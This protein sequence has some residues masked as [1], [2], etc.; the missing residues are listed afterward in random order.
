MAIVGT[1]LAGML[2]AKARHTRQLAEAERQLAAVRAADELI[3][4][5][6]VSSTG[7]PIGRQGVVPGDV[8]WRW[9]TNIVENDSIRE[10]RAR[11]VRVEI[12]DPSAGASDAGD[13]SKPIITVE[14]VVP[15]VEWPGD[16]EASERKGAD[17]D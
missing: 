13:A 9:R 16:G 5:W 17:H 15:V 12:Q 14:L 11:V 8:P 2:T 6:W 4:A 7:V 3:A 10:L 1:L